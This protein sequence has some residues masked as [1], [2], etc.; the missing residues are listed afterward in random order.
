[1]LTGINYKVC[2]WSAEKEAEIIHSFDV[3]IMPLL[4]TDFNKGKCGFKL[5]QYMACGIPTISTPLIA[6]VKINRNKKNL[7]ASN[8][9]EWLASFEKIIEQK[10]YYREI[11]GKENREIAKNFYSAEA[12]YTK[13]IR[14][15]S[16][17]SN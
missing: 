2:E 7:H 10:E 14:L 16:Q 15:F 5:I 11:V 12:N 3:G 4:D 6:N 1:M 9:D 13:Y 17:L 8:A